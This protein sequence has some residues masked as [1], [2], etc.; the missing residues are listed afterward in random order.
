MTAP[1]NILHCTCVLRRRW[2]A[3][4][5]RKASAAGAA[6]LLTALAMPLALVPGC[7]HAEV[8][9]TV[10]PALRY[11][12]NVFALPDGVEPV[13]GHRADTIASATASA[14]AVLHPR[15]YTVDLSAD[16]SYDV[17]TRNTA[18]NN[19]GYT[20][21]ANLSPAADQRIAFSG[22]VSLRRMLS[23]FA[24]IGTPVRN[25]QNYLD[26]AP[27]AA[28]HLGG[29]AVLI[30]APVYDRSTNSAS[31]F[32]AYD[33]ERYGAS[34]GFGWH[35]PLGNAIDLTVTER[36]TKGLSPRRFALGDVVVNQP[37]DLRD[38]SIDLAV[39]YQ[40]SPITRIKARGSYVWRRDFTA[41]GHS[42]NAPFGEATLT[43]SPSTALRVEANLGWRQE[44]QDQIFVD[45]VRTT[46][47]SLN[48][49]WNLGTRWQLAGRFDYY[50]RK[51]QYDPIALIGSFGLTSLQRVEHF[52]KVDAGVTYG[53]SSHLQVS[54]HASHENRS[55]SYAYATY[56]AN[57][58]LVTLTYAFGGSTTS[59]GNGS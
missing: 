42:Y 19:F 40:L 29:E 17:Y 31:L 11:D 57:V 10:A 9:G 30:V 52:T 34:V 33:Y 55:S 28:V 15:G 2:G 13:G 21:G 43:L 4:P 53:L 45:S 20:F 41:L 37:T 32:S 26:I 58:A 46:S 27:Q 25:T 51:F 50:R 18:Y 56:H 38:R 59:G 6:S 3:R 36:R 7:A 14:D 5:A 12:D 39:T 1:T 48:A 35:T 47:A 44:T 8:T 16:V 49:T 22:D 54:A 23:S 24:S